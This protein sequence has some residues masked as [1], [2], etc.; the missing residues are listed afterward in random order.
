[1]CPLLLSSSLCKLPLDYQ[2]LR[3]D[4]LDAVNF[5]HLQESLYIWSAATTYSV[6][7]LRK[8][9][10][11]TLKEQWSD[12]EDRDGVRLSW[13]VFPSS[14]MVRKRGEGIREL[15]L[16]ENRKHHGL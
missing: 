6:P 15:R 1:M 11:E 2:P 7:A 13:N 9:E 16:I 14:R 5:N 12:V 3:V 10:Y 8:M 4:K